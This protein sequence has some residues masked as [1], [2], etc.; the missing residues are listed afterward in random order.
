M[1]FGILIREET[2]LQIKVEIANQYLN[3]SFFV[4]R[5]WPFNDWHKMWDE[6]L[7]RVSINLTDSVA[8]SH[9]RSDQNIET[10]YTWICKLWIHNTAA[11]K[12]LHNM[13]HISA[14]DVEKCMF[15][16]SHLD[17]TNCVKVVWGIEKNYLAMLSKKNRNCQVLHFTEE[18]FASH[19]H[20]FMQNLHL[21]FL[22]EKHTLFYLSQ[23]ETHTV[24][25]LFRSE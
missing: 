16:S 25:V 1:N 12:Y 23:S 14:R 18:K 15:F 10:S 3:S 19:L 9:Y 2:P 13:F 24:Y 7:L 5:R 21:K 22:M 4:S 6:F 20:R 17:S 8:I 11:M